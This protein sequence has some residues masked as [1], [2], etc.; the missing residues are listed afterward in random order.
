MW[1]TFDTRIICDSCPL[2]VVNMFHDWRLLQKRI[3]RCVSG[4]LYMQFLVDIKTCRWSAPANLLNELSVIDTALGNSFRMSSSGWSTDPSWARVSGTSVCFKWR[5]TLA[6]FKESVILSLC[7]H[8]TSR[9]YQA[10]HT[11]TPPDTANPVAGT[12]HSASVQPIK[13]LLPDFAT[14]KGRLSHPAI[15][16]TTYLK[17]YALANRYTAIRAV[18]NAF[19]RNLTAVYYNRYISERRTKS[20]PPDPESY[21]CIPESTGP[22][23]ALTTHMMECKPSPSVFWINQLVMFEAVSRVHTNSIVFIN[24]M[25]I[26]RKQ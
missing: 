13:N 7:G 23:A 21:H 4:L 11:G 14:E 2:L 17:L 3:D 10:S 1:R 19:T 24:S 16:S 5:Y 18:G 20:T 26:F 6:W 25:R 22:F 8:H 15:T 12:D 9:K